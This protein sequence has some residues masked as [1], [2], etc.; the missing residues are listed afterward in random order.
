MLELD[1]RLDMGAL[2]EIEERLEVGALLEPEERLEAVPTLEIEERRLE[3]GTGMR[4]GGAYKSKNW[5]SL[6]SV[7]LGG[8]RCVGGV[9]RCSSGGRATGLKKGKG[10]GGISALA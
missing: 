7:K 1:V 2:F 9:R 10:G 8:R 4:L 5:R 6:M 3:V